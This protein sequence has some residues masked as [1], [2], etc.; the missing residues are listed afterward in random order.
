MPLK[1][2][3]TSLAVSENITLLTYSVLYPYRQV[4]VLFYY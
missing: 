2:Y 4:F 3:P 1:I